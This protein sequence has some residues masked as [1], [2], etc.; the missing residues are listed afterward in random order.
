MQNNAN[1]V[2][3]QLTDE[4]PSG[5]T[6]LYGQYTI[7]RHLIDG[8]FGMTYLA[9]DSLARRVVIKECFP[10]AICRRVVGEVRPRKPCY[11]NEFHSVIGNFL[12]E[13]LW[14]AKFEHP[15]IVKVHQVFQENNTAY[16]A[17]DFVDG[18]DLLS[19]LDNNARRLTD[20]LLNN[21]L[22]DT[23]K[24]LEYVHEFGML[25]RDISPDNLLL[26]ADDKLTLID[27]GAAREEN[28]RRTRAMST[29]L[30]V[31]DGYSPHEFYY[32]DGSQGPSSDLYSLGAT[33]Y[34]LITGY[35]PPDSQ[36]RLAALSSGQPDPCIP[37]TCGD[38]AFGQTFLSA[39]DKA[40]SVSQKKRFQ[41]VSEWIDVL[42]RSIL[43]PE[44]E[45]TP[46]KN[47]ILKA[48]EVARSNL[49]CH[50]DTSTMED[51]RS[52][53]KKS[54]QITELE[55]GIA[56]AIASL[57]QDTN[58]GLEAALLGQTRPIA[59]ALAKA[60]EDEND[61]RLV[62]MFGC[63][64]D[65]VDEWLRDQDKESKRLHAESRGTAAASNQCAN[66]KGESSG[67]GFSRMLTTFVRKR[68]R[69]SSTV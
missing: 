34:H 65:D 28:R 27:F 51:K 30:S 5:G 44:Q 36:K 50:H 55:P 4:L 22:R 26:D 16:I 43:P 68:L 15:N 2:E 41:S 52:K 14:L 31:K 58:I 48:G 60:E 49:A 56:E 35:A 8:G 66:S 46:A 9:R 7:E 23:L 32:T 25:H 67:F 20:V 17:M 13:A 6:L 33:F 11:Q 18:M 38:W 59:E 3:D 21:L 64:I 61:N 69:S 39:I 54:L 10:S 12:R 24:A 57:V 62:D 29:V 1:P 37:L 63:P 40:L 19:I 53:T 45:A 47:G 42:E